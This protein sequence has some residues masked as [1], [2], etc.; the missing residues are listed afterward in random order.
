ME[1]QSRRGDEP[2]AT[3]PR[4]PA[5]YGVDSTTPVAAVPWAAVAEQLANARNYWVVTT[6]PDGRPHAAPVWG[7]WLDERLLFSTDRASQKARNL[8]ARPALLAHLE[9]GDDAVIVEGTAEEVS[10]RALLARFADAYE[11]KYGW[12]PDVGSEPG[13]VYA[14]RPRVACTWSEGDF[15]GTGVR[16][17][18][19]ER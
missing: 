12:R 2:R 11:A 7:L 16:W 8:T 15:A 13:V 17:V 3:R 6:R 9:S 14:L 4:V 5:S 1:Q 10:D 19:Q 18:F